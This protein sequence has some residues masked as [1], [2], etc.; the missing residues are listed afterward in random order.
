M[1]GSLHVFRGV[2]MQY[3]KQLKNLVIQFLNNKS[4][5]ASFILLNSK[6]STIENYQKNCIFCKILKKEEPGVNIYEVR[7][8]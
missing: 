2:E 4:S 1:C 8:Y 3:L 6:M 5:R 7:D